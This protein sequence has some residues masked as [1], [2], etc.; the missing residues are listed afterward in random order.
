MEDKKPTIEQLR[1]KLEGQRDR[2]RHF[3]K[4]PDGKGA[5]EFLVAK[6]GGEVHQPGRD[7]FDCAVR[8]GERNVIDYLIELMGE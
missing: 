1:L 6:Y 8:I 5:I 4:S 7:P 2:L 3:V